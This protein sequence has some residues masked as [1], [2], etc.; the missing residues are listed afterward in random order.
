MVDWKSFEQRVKKESLLQRIPVVKVPENVR[1]IRGQTIY[2]KTEFDFCAS[3]DSI[4]AFF[5]C[6]CMAGNVFNFKSYVLREK[7]IHQWNNLKS[8]SENLSI[9]GYLIY[10]Y[11]HQRIVWASVPIV[12]DAMDRG[13]KALT[14][15]SPGITHQSDSLPVNLRELMKSDRQSV[16]QKLGAPS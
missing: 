4:A 6:K 5:D 14:L 12:Q 10:F 9:A 3:V 1:V 13:D 11:D 16:L 7:K 2:Q 8:C 15:S